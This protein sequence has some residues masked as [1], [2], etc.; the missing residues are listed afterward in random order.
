MNNMEELLSE[1]E[2]EYGSYNSSFITLT[3]FDM[4]E[5]LSKLVKPLEEKIEELESNENEEDMKS[6]ITSI[7]NCGCACR[8][9][10]P[11]VWEI[12]GEIDQ[13]R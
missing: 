1:L 6:V 9:C 8:C 3:M 2:E 10:N 13:G 12:A 11:K 4:E 7:R 5:I